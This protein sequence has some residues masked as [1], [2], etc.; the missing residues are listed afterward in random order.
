MVCSKYWVKKITELL[1]KNGANPNIYDGD[2]GITPLHK[3][4]Y[5]NN[6]EIVGLLIKY[7]ADRNCK[8]KESKEIINNLNNIE[9]ATPLH[10]AVRSQHKII[11]IFLKSQPNIDLNIKDNNNLTYIDYEV[12]KSKA[13]YFEHPY[14]ALIFYKME[15]IKENNEV[16]IIGENG[17]D[18]CIIL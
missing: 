5:D 16:P 14:N 15:K 8:V 17:C 6:L 4:V 2:Y 12:G 9:G 18:S 10:L 13:P 1:L 11:E 3:A 7:N